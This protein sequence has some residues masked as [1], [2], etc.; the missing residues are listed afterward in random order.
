MLNNELLDLVVVESDFGNQTVAELESA[1][2]MFKDS[3]P[4]LLHFLWIGRD[5]PASELTRNEKEE[6]LDKLQGFG[7]VQITRRTEVKQS[8][9]G[10]TYITTTP[11]TVTYGLT[12]DGRQFLLRLRLEVNKQSGAGEKS[13]GGGNLLNEAKD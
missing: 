1:L 5:V 11:P 2:A 7:L 12:D 4:T 6:L 10:G 8:G 13:P 3:K 9:F